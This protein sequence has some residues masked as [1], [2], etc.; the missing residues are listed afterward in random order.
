M[1]NAS[2][3]GGY[4][5]GLDIGANSVGWSVVREEE[6]EGVGV[7]RLGV[8]CFEAGVEGDIESG[9]DASRAAKRRTAR[10]MRR[11][12]WRRQRRLL[13]VLRLLQ[14]HD[15]MPAGKVS[16][17]D[18]RH[19]L[20]LKLDNTLRQKWIAKADRV[21]QHLLPYLLRS[22]A[23]EQPLE[24]HE[25]G[26][27]LYHL[28]QRRGFKSNRK[29]KEGRP[30]EDKQEPKAAADKDKKQGLKEEIK[31]L[32]DELREV[33]L[34]LGQFF[35]RL[36]P[37]QRRIRG[38]HT[39][40]R[41]YEEEF[42]KIWAAQAA[43]HPSSL[44][45]EARKAIRHAT[46]VQRPLKSAKGLIGH[47]TLEPSR[48]RAAL[49]L[50]IAQCFRM[51]QKVNDLTVIE[52]TG[53]ER[54]LK[55]D[56]RKKLLNALEVQ[57]G[58]TFKQARKL[59]GLVE[60]RTRTNKDTGRKE[61]AKLGH[62]FN[63]ESGGE[64]K[65]PGNR[66]TARMLPVFGQRWLEM[67]REEQEAVVVEILG[68]QNPDALAER[69]RK[70][71]GLTEKE[72]A[73]LAEVDL[74]DERAAHCRTALVRL[75]EAMEDGTA[76]A[77]AK[78]R[79]YPQ[80]SKPQ[81]AV[82]QL[83]PVK[84]VIKDL[85][86]PA[87]M[88]AL[89]EVRK[90]VN[91]VVRCYGK[92]S[93]VRIELARDLKRPR[94]DRERLTKQNRENE[95]ERRKAKERLLA[96]EK[97]PGASA[98]DV[99]KVLLADECGWRCPYTGRQMTWS[100]LFGP[101][102]QFD[103]EHILPRRYLDNSFANKTLCDVAFNR[104]RKRDRLPAEV[105]DAGSE[106]WREV[107]D[108]LS[109]FTGRLG[110]E[111]L[112]RFQLTREAVA[113]EF[114]EEYPV[115]ALSDTR[116]ASRLAGEYVALL[117]GGQVDENGRR[118][119]QVSSG[120][121]TALLRAQ[122]GLND[123]L[124]SLDDCPNTAAKGLGEKLRAD[125]RHHAID[126][127]V[128]ALTTP[129]TTKRLADEAERAAARGERRSQIPAPW[130]DLYEQTRQA[131]GHVVVSH[132]ADRKVGGPLHAETVYSKRFTYAGKEG[133]HHVRRP[134]SRLSVQDFSEVAQ[135]ESVTRGIVDKT[136]REL[137]RKKWEELGKGEP[138]KV[139]QKDE[140]HPCLLTRDGRRIP[141]H[142]VRV[143]VGDNPVKLGKGAR[144]RYVD[145]GKDTLHHTCIVARQTRQG[146][147]WED[148]PADRLTVHERLSKD[149]PLIGPQLAAGERM[150]MWL[151]KGDM[152]EMDEE[153]GARALYVVRGIS[154]RDIKVRRHN[155]A[156]TDQEI[157]EAGERKRFRIS[158]ADTLRER[159]ARKMTISPL[160]EV[161]PREIAGDGRADR[162]HIGGGG[163]P[164]R[165]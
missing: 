52:P 80:A 108:R 81:L 65:L 26:R 9:R 91:A 18:E 17:A 150:V 163:I 111:K 12:N 28:A 76:F 147:R 85:K 20:L 40:R 14:T 134:V 49:A 120:Q 55:A 45:E 119:V 75:V 42:D 103:V 114:G 110:K 82:E 104:N 35:A 56:E 7:E 33:G 86:N 126:A 60:T 135:D 57:G 127:V 128:V 73:E 36:D 102:P 137:V 11:Q 29:D 61:I 41:M 32:A 148:R 146:E 151:C 78:L 27:A 19:V 157:Q 143:A 83:P 24:L 87:V 145:S 95:A 161:W 118:R 79:L 159:N 72:A 68:F 133:V 54:D 31:H 15:L 123:I 39:S 63:L 98:Q 44:T 92:P 89:T 153:K 50:P 71:W 1:S 152:I 109:R 64:E 13:R 8:R 113:L 2:G 74:E 154:Q 38:Q 4:V 131:A 94:K 77:T 23:L 16:Q 6:G 121:V 97:L 58:L 67:K 165:P 162:R 141:I 116:Y 5:I 138:A 160:G 132:R 100:T 125:H 84:T 66:T 90:V 156:R 47:C 112:R 48:R 144:E 115:R 93:A 10:L 106:E 62:H 46:F 101:E 96:E 88:R 53:E 117:F 43:H 37:E 140:S 139:F 105:F 149:K 21:G 136:I 22:R 69:A 70:A 122:W 130:N 59:L 124:P 51:L 25:L 158:S 3:Q 129:A 107:M 155:D 164:A 34:T 99:E 30:Q 142:R